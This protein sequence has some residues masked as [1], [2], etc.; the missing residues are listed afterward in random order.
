M[1]AFRDPSVREQHLPEH[2]ILKG[3]VCELLCRVSGEK[4]W[5][6]NMREMVKALDKAAWMGLTG[7]PIGKRGGGDGLRCTEVIVQ[8]KQGK[9]WEDLSIQALDR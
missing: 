7:T 3:Q 8:T 4:T 9:N 2:C 6:A 5:A 1:P